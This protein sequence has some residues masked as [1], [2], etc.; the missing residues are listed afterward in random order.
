MF[1]CMFYFTCDR[2]LTSVNQYRP[3]RFITDT[4]TQSTSAEQ[5]QRQ[6]E[7]F[8]CLLPLQQNMSPLVGCPGPKG[9]LSGERE[10]EREREPNRKVERKLKLSVQFSS[11]TIFVSR[12]S[13]IIQGYDGCAHAQKL[14]TNITDISWLAVRGAYARSPSSLRIST[15]QAF[16]AQH[17]SVTDKQKKQTKKDKL[18]P[19]APRGV[20]P[21]SPNSQGMQRLTHPTY[22]I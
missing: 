11:V 18:S 9:F 16:C 13:L 10:R 21:R 8:N 20:D 14:R 7:W 1:Y 12:A 19:V 17:R 22:F 6:L 15:V 2:S 5:Q 4:R 3:L